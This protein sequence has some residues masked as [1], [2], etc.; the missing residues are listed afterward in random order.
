M[1]QQKEEEKQKHLAETLAKKEKEK[2]AKTQKQDQEK[3]QRGD[4]SKAKEPKELAE[5]E[6]NDEQQIDCLGN[7]QK[8]AIDIDFKQDDG[9]EV[10]VKPTES[11]IK[12]G[13][14]KKTKPAPAVVA[15]KMADLLSAPDDEVVQ[16]Q[17]NFAP[18]EV[19][20]PDYIENEVDDVKDRELHEKQKTDEKIKLEKDLKEQEKLK[21]EEE[22]KAKRE[23]E[24]LA[25]LQ[26]KEAE[27]LEKLK[28]EEEAKAKKE[29]AMEERRLK[30]EKETIEKQ[31]KEEEKLKQLEETKAKKEAEKPRGDDS[32]VKESEELAEVEP[33][34]EQHI[35]TPD[36]DQK[37]AIGVDFKQVDGDEITVQSTESVIK[38]G[39][40]KNTKPAPAVV[41]IKMADLLSAP[42]DEVDQDQKNTATADVSSPDNIDM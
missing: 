33:N 11:V 17:E 5:A 21:K 4:E 31:Q 39:V 9:N 22:A 40:P 27:K 24:R 34:D 6:D 19:S 8:T 28:K 7:D 25:K 38:R 42:D 14:P 16:D 20:P 3:M 13:I 30:Q 35:D 37:K 12:R 2:L 32:K 1:G 41:A 10:K 29:K 15:I 36:N 18:G 26:K 23:Q